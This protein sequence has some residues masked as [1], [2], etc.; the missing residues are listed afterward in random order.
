VGGSGAEHGGQD[1]HVGH[2][3]HLVQRIQGS[4]CFFVYGH[5]LRNQ[6]LLRLISR[7]R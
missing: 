3:E 2:A 7:V 6:T 1:A 4:G 5:N